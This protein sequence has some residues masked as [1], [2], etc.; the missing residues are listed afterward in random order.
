MR[1][2]ALASKAGDISKKYFVGKLYTS[3]RFQRKSGLYKMPV[4]QFLDF[5]DINFEDLH[6]GMVFAMIGQVSD[7]RI[8]QGVAH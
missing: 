4:P 8:D 1:S 2:S 3:C 6:C 7:F 5:K